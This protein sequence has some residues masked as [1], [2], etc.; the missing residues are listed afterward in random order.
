[1]PR[2]WQFRMRQIEKMMNKTPSR[3]IAV[4]TLGTGKT[5]FLL[6]KALL[7]HKKVLVFDVKNDISIKDFPLSKEISK[8]VK[9]VAIIDLPLNDKEFVEY[10]DKFDAFLFRFEVHDLTNYAYTMG[11]IWKISRERLDDIA[12][13]L[14]EA[15]VFNKKGFL[16]EMSWL[17]TKS[18]SRNISVYATCTRLPYVDKALRDNTTD[19]Y[20]FYTSSEKTIN[21][22]EEMT[23]K[24]LKK[25]VLDLKRF[26]Y[27]HIELKP[28]SKNV[29]RDSR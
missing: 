12:V 25:N 28:K 19:Y 29:S 20:I 14:D 27:I 22:I 2:L 10:Y 13:F 17:S 16:V 23:S 6:T 9:E 1:M 21:E 24:K 5:T 11:Q 26:E 4:G 15:E 3:E 18:R 8:K 7:S